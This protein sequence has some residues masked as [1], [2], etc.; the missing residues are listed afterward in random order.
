MK[1]RVGTSSND[2]LT[3]AFDLLSLKHSDA[4]VLGGKK[5]IIFHVIC[6]DLFLSPIK[7][8]HGFID[9]PTFELMFQCLSHAAEIFKITGACCT[10]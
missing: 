2:L 4:R 9:D 10:L 7:A 8:C 1:N 5:L 3:L 6:F